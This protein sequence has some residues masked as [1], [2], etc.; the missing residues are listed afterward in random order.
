MPKDEIPRGQL[1]NIILSTLLD[2]DKYG[3]EIIEIIKQKTNGNI[4]IKQ[5][6]LYSSLR[7]MEEQGLISSYWRDSEIG[8]RRHYYSITDYG[9]KYAEKW[10]TDLSVFSTNDYTKEIKTS[11][12]ANEESHQQNITQ[13]TILQQENLF[14]NKIVTKEDDKKEPIEEPHSF[15]QFD[16]FTSPTLISEPSNEVF[17]SIK[18]LRESADNKQSDEKDDKIENLS[19]L[20]NKQSEEIKTSYVAENHNIY[21]NSEIDDIKKN[22][23]ELTKKQKSFADAL[24]DN[25]FTNDNNETN[26][27]D[28]LIMDSIQSSNDLDIPTSNTFEES[29]LNLEQILKNKEDNKNLNSELSSYKNTNIDNNKIDNDESFIEEQKPTIYQTTKFDSEQNE[30][31][32]R[33][34]FNSSSVEFIDLNNIDYN[35]Q[36][37][38]YNEQAKETPFETKENNSDLVEN[39]NEES[40]KNSNPLPTNK[41]AGEE[42]NQSEIPTPL[43][44]NINKDDAV[45]ITDKPDF[46]NMPK[47]KKIAPARFENYA[48]NYTDSLNKKIS[49]HFQETVKVD[50]SL[51]K[52]EVVNKNEPTTK[53]NPEYYND[54]NSLKN[55][56]NE[57]GLKFDI[58]KKQN[59][60]HN[61]NY[62]KVNKMNFISYLSISVLAIIEAIILFCTFRLLQPSW[63]WLYL[64][65]PIVAIGFTTFYMVKFII[66]KN[67]VTNKSNVLNY[68][69]IYRIL[70]C[71]IFIMI[72]FSINLLCGMS[73]DDISN[74]V[75]TFIYPSIFILNYPL[76]SFVNY[77]LFKLNV[78][79][80]K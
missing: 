39:N 43:S 8:G 14:N 51:N 55:Y 74:Y 62:V 9:K 77:I 20:R 31:N 52:E 32:E 61:L 44:P 53:E 70:M 59:N 36:K 67:A 47:V 5:P 18:K 76:L 22:F 80:L 7:R 23:F 17:D 49:A 30:E 78:I 64:L 26:I 45:L 33:E 63:N 58:Y 57:Y 38:T 12:N 41:L 35:T 40:I 24:K 66:N 75:T 6:S 27:T 16:L 68:N 71:I 3:Y 25:E 65:L 48:R 11:T 37:T 73:F 72:V 15:V 13:G 29:S 50:D 42:L 10:Q 21:S 1:S 34:I 69:F 19:N 28:E 56:Y 4:T 2:N 79:N 54:L 46:S 60:I